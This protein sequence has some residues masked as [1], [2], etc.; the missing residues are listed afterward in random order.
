MVLLFNVLPFV[1]FVA[2][3]YL[4]WKVRKPL[5]AALA[6]V[7][8]LGYNLAQPSY[9]PKGFVPRTELPVF[10]GSRSEITDRLLKPKSGEEYDKAREQSYKN[11]LPFIEQKGK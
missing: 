3:L 1:V 4:S 7:L 11:G 10:E 9:G 5:I 6:V 8:L 2:L